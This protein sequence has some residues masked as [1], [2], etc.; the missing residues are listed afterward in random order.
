GRHR[1]NYL[2]RVPK[3]M[4]TSAFMQKRLQSDLKAS[5]GY[6]VV[7]ESRMM[8]YWRLVTTR[9]GRR[10][11]RSKHTDGQYK[12]YVDKEGN[13]RFENADVRDLIFQLEIRYGYGPHGDLV[14]RP[15]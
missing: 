13:V 7:V 4:G 15:G 11:L 2:L 6:D 12:V 1:F 14:R 9:R 8:P 10:L 5:F 3:G